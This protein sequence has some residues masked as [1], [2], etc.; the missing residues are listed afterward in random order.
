MMPTLQQTAMNRKP[1]GQAVSRVGARPQR[2]RGAVRVFAELNNSSPDKLL[3]N[4]TQQVD[5]FLKVRL[6][7]NPKAPAEVVVV[8]LVGKVFGCAPELS[9]GG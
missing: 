9:D 1:F 7:P 2:T 4:V 6:C 3:A 5:S 8:I